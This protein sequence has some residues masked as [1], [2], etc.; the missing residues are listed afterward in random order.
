MLSGILRKKHYKIRH[1][2]CHDHIRLEIHAFSKVALHDFDS[3]LHMVFFHI[4]MSYTHRILIDFNAQDLTASQQSSTDRKDPRTAAHVQDLLLFR[5]FP[6]IL[7]HQLHAK[8]RRLMCP[9]PKSHPRIDLNDQLIFLRRIFFPGRLYHDAIRYFS[10]LEELFPLIFP[11]TIV[12]DVLCNSQTA[13]I[14]LLSEF[15]CLLTSLQRR[16]TT[17]DHDSHLLCLWIWLVEVQ[18]NHRLP[19]KIFL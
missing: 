9:R 13:E 4:F 6:K 2:I 14:C 7:F 3:I 8:R 19:I 10:R 15:A 12:H 1:E 17:L 11:V 5:M 16:N 18:R